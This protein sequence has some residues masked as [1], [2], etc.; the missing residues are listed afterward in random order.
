[1]DTLEYQKRLADFDLEIQRAKLIAQESEYKRAQFIATVLSTTLDRQ[2][3]S[4][5]PGDI[6]VTKQGQ[7]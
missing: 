5:I 6:S 3:S 2:K 7:Q 1:M 4:T